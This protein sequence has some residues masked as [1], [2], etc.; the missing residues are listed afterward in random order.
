MLSAR[1]MLGPYFKYRIKGKKT[2]LRRGLRFGKKK[3]EIFLM[4]RR[5]FRMSG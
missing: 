4:L 3:G 1:R 5:V 2:R